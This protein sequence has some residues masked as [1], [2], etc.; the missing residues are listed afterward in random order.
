MKTTI[1]LIAL[2]LGLHVLAARNV[3]LLSSDMIHGDG[4]ASRLFPRLR[5][6]AMRIDAPH[7]DAGRMAAD[8]A[9]VYYPGKDFWRASWAYVEKISPDPWGRESRYPPADHWLV[10][11]TLAHL[12]YGYASVI[13]IGFQYLLFLVCFIYAFIALG[14]ERRYLYIGLLCVNVANLWKPVLCRA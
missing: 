13:H 12:P 8:F 4:A 6:K 7:P 1:F 2:A 9:Q 3:A 10:A 5:Y 11:A 14:L